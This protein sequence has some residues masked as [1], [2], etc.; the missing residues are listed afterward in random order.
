M[1]RW[2]IRI[3]A[4]LL[5]CMAFAAAATAARVLSSTLEVQVLSV[6]QGPLRREPGLI[7]QG[8]VINW[9]EMTDFTATVQIRNVIRSDYSLASGET[10]KIHYTV[11]SAAPRPGK[12][13]KPGD[14]LTLTV[15]KGDDGYVWRP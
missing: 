1:K 5:V 3:A 11:R 9:L 6:D 14:D 12:P 10:I 8:K 2:S 15:L 13:L 4:S 7:S